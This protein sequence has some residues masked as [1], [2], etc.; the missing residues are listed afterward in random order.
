MGEGGIQ[1]LINQAKHLECGIM[2]YV[3]II[4]IISPLINQQITC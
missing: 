3:V 2:G 1:R 4:I